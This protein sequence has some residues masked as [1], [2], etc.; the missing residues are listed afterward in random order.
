MNPN[1]L[2]DLWNRLETWLAANDPASLQ[3]LQPGATEEEILQTEAFL[4]VQFPE[5]FK[6]SYRIH[7][8]QAKYAND[9]IYNREFLCLERIRDEW[10]VW[11]DLLDSG[12]FE[13]YKS[14][15]YGPI[16]D[17]WWDAK[18]IPVTYDGSGNHDCLDLNPAEG[19][20][21]GQVIDF[22]H[23]D[24]LRL[25]KADGFTAWLAKFVE[26]CENGTYVYSEEYGG[27]AHIDDI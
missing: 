12:T 16:R 8:G 2:P 1:S 23:D 22:W 10:K 17:D 20:K 19:G 5:E 11:K 27:V 15:P 26:G 24:A 21:V 13:T 25:V 6:A 7:N 3:T 18:W 4:A 9:L 14:E